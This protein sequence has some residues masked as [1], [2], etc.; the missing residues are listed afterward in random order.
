[1]TSNAKADNNAQRCAA[2]TAKGEPCRNRALPGQAFCRMHLPVNGQNGARSNGGSGGPGGGYGPFGFDPNSFFG[3]GDGNAG[4]GQGQ[5]PDLAQIAFLLEQILA[6][7]SRMGHDAPFQHG[8]SADKTRV[9]TE[10]F[11]KALAFLEEK[12]AVIKRRVDGDYEVDKWGRDLELLAEMLPLFQFLYRS[13]WRVTAIGVENVP[14]D[15]RA[16]LVANHSGVVPWDAVMVMT[17]ILECHEKP[18]Y[19]RGLYLSWAAEMPF[20]GLFMNRLGQVQ[21]LPENAVRLLNEDELVMVFPE[22]AKGIGK[23]FSERYQLARFGRGGFVRAA[24]KAKAPII[25]VS[26]VGAE[27]I[28]PMIGNAAPV[29]SIFNMPYVPI[30]PTFPLLGPLGLLPLPS[31]WTIHFGKP[32]EVKD[33]LQSPAGEPLLVTKITNEVREIIQKNIHEILKKRRN[34]FW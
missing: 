16:L 27:E 29:A 34:V 11:W 15:G 32:I 19:A 17:A 9:A 8:P 14:A 31:K 26:V 10:L 22:G 13:Y 30:T 4:Q 1:M 3:A 28:H 20:M 21:A 2:K 25:P 18:R 23:P 6:H 24:L 33:L 5:S 7:L 12:I